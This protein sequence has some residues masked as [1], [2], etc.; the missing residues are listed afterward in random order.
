MQWRINVSA[1]LVVLLGVLGLT[2]YCNGWAQGIALGDG[3]PDTM[4]MT[5]VGFVLAGAALAC[6][7][8]CV[9]G[10]MYVR[11][12]AAVQLVTMFGFM[13]VEYAADYTL[14]VHAVL[15]PVRTLGAQTVYPG[16]PSMGTSLLF[17]LCGLYVAL[18]ERNMHRKSYVVCMGLAM[19]T[20]VTAVIALAGYAV[21][22]PV[23][24]Y[25][26]EPYS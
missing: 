21:G 7:R 4:P 23:M 9:G 2:S 5:A 26:I 10:C 6:S 20:L 11:A 1:L 18:H 19:T 17:V 3:Y 8:G 16:V 22:Q 24:Y 25:Y 13:L 14:G 15:V 12:F